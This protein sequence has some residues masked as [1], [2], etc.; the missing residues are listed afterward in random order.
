MAHINGIGKARGFNRETVKGQ[1]GRVLR[2]SVEMVVACSNSISIS[3][4]LHVANV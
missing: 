4:Y 3:K 2:T 1:G